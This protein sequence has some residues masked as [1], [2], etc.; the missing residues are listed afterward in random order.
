MNSSKEVAG[1]D[2]PWKRAVEVQDPTE[3]NAKKAETKKGTIR[4]R[5]DFLDATLS[6]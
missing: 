4:L 2:Q 6:G 5:N 3:T 1:K